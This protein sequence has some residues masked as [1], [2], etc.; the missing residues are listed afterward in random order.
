MPLDKIFVPT[1]ENFVTR[2]TLDTDYLELIEAGT[3][4]RGWVDLGRFRNCRNVRLE[5]GMRIKAGARAI[6]LIENPGASVNRTS[7]ER[8]GWKWACCGISVWGC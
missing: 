8:P 6:N 4:E 3:F 1:H 5:S 7:F 2:L